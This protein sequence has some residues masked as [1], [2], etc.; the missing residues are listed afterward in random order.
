M[1]ASAEEVAVFEDVLPPALL[2][3]VEVAADSYLATD[4]GAT[5]VPG[6]LCATHWVALTSGP[7][8][9]P[10]LA[11]P[12]SHP[13]ERAVA[14]LCAQRVLITW[15]ARRGL[16]FSGVECWLQEQG[17]DD[18]PKGMHTDRD[19]CMVRGAEGVEYRSAYP[20]ISSVFYLTTPGG[21]TAVFDQRPARD[22][23]YEPEM[24]NRLWVVPPK[25]NRCSKPPPP[26][27]KLRRRA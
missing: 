14:W 10:R 4:L 22:G 16:T 17:S 15:L 9:T 23:G 25:P 6:S 20:C 7:S 1:V 21:P 13:F 12:A 18:D 24:P 3:E 11:R 5:D 2:R 26:C 19:V 27:A 8:G